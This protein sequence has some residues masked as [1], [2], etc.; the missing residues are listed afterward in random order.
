ML[1]EGKTLADFEAKTKMVAEGA[2]AC[3]TVT[4]LAR[5]KGIDMPICEAVYSIMYE[6]A[7]TDDVIKKLFDRPSKSEF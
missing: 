5:K 7:N 6:N 4:E 1:V 2:I 3:K